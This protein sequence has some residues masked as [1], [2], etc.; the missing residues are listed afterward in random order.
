M[1]IP[2]TSTQ[3]NAVE[4]LHQEPTGVLTKKESAL[5]RAG[6]T[7]EV[8][9]KTMVAGLEAESMTVDK[10]GDEHMTPDHSSRLKAAELIS[11]LNGDLKDSPTVDARQITINGISGEA[12]ET[13]LHMVSDVSKQLSAL[14]TS[15]QQTGEIIDITI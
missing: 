10:F 4:L 13:L 2:I 3:L 9:Y 1:E 11:R 8:A 15:G 5:V 6:A 12:V 7:R 14:R